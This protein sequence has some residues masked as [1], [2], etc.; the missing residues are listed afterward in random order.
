MVFPNTQQPTPLPAKTP[1]GKPRHGFTSSF[2]QGK[3]NITQTIEAVPTRPAKPGAQRRINAALIR[4]VIENKD[5][6]PHTIETR[7]RI[8]THCN[9]D[10]ALFAAPTMPGKILDGIE[11]KDKT[12]PP[13]VQIMQQPD[14]KNPGAVGHFT[15]KPGGR[16]IGPDRFVCTAHGAGEN[17]WEV[18]VQQA[19][20]DSDCAIYWKPVTVQPGATVTLAYAYGI[21]LAGTMHSESPV[22]LHFGGSFEPSKL[23]TIT[24]YLD[25]PPGNQTLALEL[26]PGIE[27]VEGKSMQPVPQP[28]PETP[29]SLVLWKCRVQELGQHTL[30]IR[31]SDGVTHART[32]TI[33][34]P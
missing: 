6:R 19:G 10:G 11:L 26:P 3:L 27:L 34:R 16:L 31:G 14:L 25:E 33:A 30:R 20:G 4:Y 12:L 13:Y 5:A 18:N 22:R 23:F 9:N 32:I 2:S 7:V 15:L 21:G 28:L 8:D 1:Q 24:A 29:T 17:G